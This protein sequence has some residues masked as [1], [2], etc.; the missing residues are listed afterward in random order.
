MAMTLRLTDELAQALRTTAEELHVS[1]QSAAVTAI[2][3]FIE[4][5]Q[6]AAAAELATEFV[7]QN[8]ELIDRLGK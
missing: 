5:R 3:E 6:V 8:R 7:Q 4:R 1:M 2:S